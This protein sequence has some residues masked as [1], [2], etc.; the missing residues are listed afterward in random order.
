M[1]IERDVLQAIEIE[2][3][4]ELT[5]ECGDDDRSSLW[6]WVISTDDRSA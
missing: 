3:E 4:L 6:Q 5:I 1:A 2:K